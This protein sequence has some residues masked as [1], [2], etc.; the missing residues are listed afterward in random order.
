[1][2]RDTMVTVFMKGRSNTDET[3]TA[4]KSDSKAVAKAQ[5]VKDVPLTT[6]AVAKVCSY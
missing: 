6:A 4:T 3:K 2:T 1:M 5:A